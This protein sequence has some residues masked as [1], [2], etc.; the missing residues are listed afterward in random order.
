[1]GADGT[2][3]SADKDGVSH[4]S[5]GSGSSGD[6]TRER[7][8]ESGT[9]PYVEASGAFVKILTE[10]MSATSAARALHTAARTRDTPSNAALGRDSVSH[11]CCPA[12]SGANSDT[13]M[14]GATHAA[15]QRQSLAV[16][17]RPRGG[18][19][20][21]KDAVEIEGGVNSLTRTPSG[22]A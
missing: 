7:T 17:V 5:P 11:G 21:T 9:G 16:H 6:E 18:R 20:E 14:T 2:R 19:E 15:Q 12:S 22:A 8:R 1:M 4:V 13:S 10:C 3:I